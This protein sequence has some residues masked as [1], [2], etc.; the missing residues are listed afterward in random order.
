MKIAPRRKEPREGE[1]RAETGKASL[2]NVI[3]LGPPGAGK[4]TQARLLTESQGM[5]QLSTGDM[6][7]AA[8]AAG[9]EVGK[10]ADAVMKSGGL[11]SDEIVIGVVDERL[12]SRM[13][14]RV[15]SLTVS[16]AQRARRKRLTGCLS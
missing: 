3:L 1:S 4:G 13:W 2:M 9:T 16:R 15:L 5:I 10:A 6:L 14:Q 8:V 11:V 7:R 12:I